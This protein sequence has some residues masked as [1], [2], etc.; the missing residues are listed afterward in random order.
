MGNAKI[1]NNVHVVQGHLSILKFL[2]RNT[3]NFTVYAYLQSSH[4]C[5][6]IINNSSLLLCGC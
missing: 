1:K 5:K 2:T 4:N 6:A 3:H